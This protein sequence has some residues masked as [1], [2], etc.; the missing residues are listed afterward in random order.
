MKKIF[1]SAAV[2]FLL[3]GCQGSETPEDKE[4][5][6]SMPD[7]IE[8]EIA[9]KGTPTE[10]KEVII[11]TTVREGSHLLNEEGDITFEVRKSGEDK[12]EMLEAKNTGS[13]T[14]QVMHT[15][16]EQGKYFVTAHVTAKG[17]H[18]M[19]E[20]VVEI[21]GEDSE[22]ASAHPS[23]DVSIEFHNLPAKAGEKSEFTA[24][25][26][27]DGKP[28]TEADVQFEVWK[29]GKEE[30][31]FVKAAEKA[32]GL[33]NNQVSFDEP[34]TYKVQVHVEKGAL[35]EHQLQSIQVDK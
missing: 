7:T 10:G 16:G 4:V 19:P 15:F 8:A 35:H 24:N 20:K 30:S 33:Y 9:I 6:S 29:D 22:G 5:N 1:F 34:G 14:Y 21:Q 23:T 31:R 32:S 3:T 2:M 27:L 18:V 11:E 28:L 26:E 25:V 13:G 17:T 12:R